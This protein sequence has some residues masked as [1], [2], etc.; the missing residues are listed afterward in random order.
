MAPVLFNLHACLFV[1]CW[2]ERVAGTAGVGVNVKYKHDRKLF[3]RYTCNADEARFT[4]LQFADDAALLATTRAGAEGA[5]YM[6]IDVAADF[7]LSVNVSKTKLMVTGRKATADDR[8]LILV[9]DDRIESVIEFPYLGSVIASPGRMLPDIDQR[10]AKASRAFGALRKSVFNSRDLRVETKSMVYQACVLSVLLYGSECWTPLRK[11]LKKLDSFHHRCICTIL[12]ISNQQ[13]WAQ[14][15]TSQS[16]RQQWRDSEA[17]AEKVSKRRLEWLGHLARMPDYR[18][19]KISLFSWLPEPRSRG[20]PRK[21]WRHVI[22]A[23]LKDRNI[24][25][26]VWYNEAATS[27][28]VWRATYRQACADTNYR[29][30]HQEHAAHQVQCLKCQRTFRRECDMK[31][32][33]ERRKPV[34]EQR[35][36]VQCPTCKRWF[37]SRGG[38]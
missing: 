13:Q 27:R 4:D 24:S 34:S 31:S 18:T 22:R 14:H 36:A 28:A 29:E 25:E 16:V 38:L 9:G 17:V 21:R 37:C 1:E 33:S 15:I 30:Q 20:G 35:G 11:D 32:L 3:R 8:A 26:E 23:D 10:I 6:Y 7:G 12:G 19:P 2:T 5:L